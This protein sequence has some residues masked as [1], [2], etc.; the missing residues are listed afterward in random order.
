MGTMAPRRL[1]TPW[2]YS[3]VFGRAVTVSQPLISW[4]LR[5]STPYSAS[6]RKKVRYWR[7]SRVTVDAGSVPRTW[8]IS[9]R[10]LLRQLATPSQCVAALS[11]GRHGTGPDGAGQQHPE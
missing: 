4:T 8:A 7:A 9:I 3:G 11:T 10:S 5:M 6:A 1:I 2:T